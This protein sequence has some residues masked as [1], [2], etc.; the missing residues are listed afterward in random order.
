[1][2]DANTS[3]PGHDEKHPATPL[4]ENNNSKGNVGT[5][6]EV[7]VFQIE[8][9]N[10]TEEVSLRRSQRTSKFSAK[11][12]EFILDNKVKYG[13]NRYDNHCVL[14]SENYGFVSNL[15]KFVEPSSYEEASRDINWIKYKSNGEVERYKAR[16]VAKW[17]SRKEGINYEETF[18]PMVKMS[19]VRPVMTP[20]PGNLVLHHKETDVDKPDISYYVHCLSQHVHVLL[21]SHF[22][23]ALR[24]LKYLKL[25][26]GL[27]VE[28]VKRN[29]ERVVS[30][31]SDLD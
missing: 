11:L 19:I 28:F 24:V 14:S 7:P 16:L 6:D 31:Y 22:D 17:H 5:Y 1:M 30:A 15:N 18:N 23:I 4:D 9:S 13:L 3:Q 21:K 27:G 25:A 20:L 29:S 2:T 26:L 8:L 12:N 10:T